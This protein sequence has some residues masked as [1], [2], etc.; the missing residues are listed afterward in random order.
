MPDTS[1]GPAEAAL[2]A[3]PATEGRSEQ[4]YNVQLVQEENCEKPAEAT[5]HHANAVM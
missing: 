2:P 4:M 3:A 5:G 1:L